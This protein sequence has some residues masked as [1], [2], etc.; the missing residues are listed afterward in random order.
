ELFWIKRSKSFPTSQLGTWPLRSPIHQWHR[1]RPNSSPWGEGRAMRAA[2]AVRAVARGGT[3]VAAA[4]AAVPC[5]ARRQGGDGRRAGSRAG[6][7]GCDERSSDPRVEP[8]HFPR[9]RE[10]RFLQ[11]L[12]RRGDPAELLE[13]APAG[14]AAPCGALALRLLR[15]ADRAPAWLP[16]PAELRAE[17]LAAYAEFVAAAA[18]AGGV[19]PAWASA[20]RNALA[21]A[22]AFPLLG[23]E[24]VAC[25]AAELRAR[26]ARRLLDPLAGSGLH[27]ALFEACGFPATASDGRPPEVRWFAVEERAAEGVCWSA[28]SG[29]EAALL[30]SWPP[31]QSAG[32]DSALEG[33]QGRWLVLVGDGGTWTGS[34]DFHGALASGWREVWRRE[35]LRWPAMQDDL[36][37][38]ERAR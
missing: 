29:G 14:G 16:A 8:A 17:A 28:W 11:L 33:F 23:P 21:Q 19:P 10:W 6:A 5:S 32:G 20:A 4:A 24:D 36:R 34:A 30:L 27:A 31:R 35:I 9:T 2:A 12:R 37:I 13:E 22:Y 7:V 18:A 15:L 26:G 25:A 3:L 38:Y 1:A